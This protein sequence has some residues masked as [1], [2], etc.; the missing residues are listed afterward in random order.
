M[1]RP[2]IGSAPSCNTPWPGPIFQEDGVTAWLA[3]AVDPLDGSN[4][5]FELFRAQV[6]NHPMV[7]SALRPVGSLEAAL[8]RELGA[9]VLPGTRP[10]E[11]VDDVRALPIHQRGDGMAVQIVDSPTQEHGVGNLKFTDGWR[12]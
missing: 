12:E 8:R 3:I 11:G 10:H 4:D 6:R 5:A 9:A 2:T 7:H 1:E